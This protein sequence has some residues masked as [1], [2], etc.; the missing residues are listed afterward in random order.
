MKLDKNNDSEEILFFGASN[1]NCS[2]V[3]S[4]FHRQIVIAIFVFSVFHHECHL[5]FFWRQCI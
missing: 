4:V 2:I 3:T 5:E 1:C